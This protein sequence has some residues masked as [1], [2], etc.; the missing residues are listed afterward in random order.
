[1]AQTRK[2]AGWRRAKRRTTVT[3]RMVGRLGARPGLPD[4][5]PVRAQPRGP[6]A[7]EWT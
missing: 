3:P 4:L 6:A 1:M 7:E 2:A 5:T